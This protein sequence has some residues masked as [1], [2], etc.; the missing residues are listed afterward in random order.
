MVLVVVYLY[1]FDNIR[2]K[3]PKNCFWPPHCRL[4]K[5]VHISAQILIYRQKTGSHEPFVSLI[6]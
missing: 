2:L 4:Q 1:L 6:V 5:P 3:T